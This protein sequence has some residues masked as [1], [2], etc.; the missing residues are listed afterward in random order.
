MGL[1]NPH[2]CIIQVLS[3]KIAGAVDNVKTIRVGNK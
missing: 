1:N 3:L 2:I